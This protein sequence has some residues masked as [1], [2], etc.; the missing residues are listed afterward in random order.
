MQKRNGL[1]TFN[2]DHVV[3]HLGA[4]FEYFAFHAIALQLHVVLQSF[5]SLF[6]VR[7]VD[8]Q[9]LTKS[10]DSSFA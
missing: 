10:P 5:R 6:D 9:S 1:K 4:T 8:G 3:G 7:E 2:E